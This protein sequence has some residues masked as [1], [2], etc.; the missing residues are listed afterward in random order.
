MLSFAF[1]VPVLLYLAVI[2]GLTR[3]SVRAAG[4]MSAG[5]KESASSS[6]SYFLA[7]RGIGGWLA[8]VSVVATETSVAT[9][10]VF[11]QLGFKSGFAL[12]W[13][14]P[15]Y[16]VGR[17]LVARYYL[18][19]L[20]SG[21]SLS[22]YATVT[23]TPGAQRV[24]SLA[25]LA[26][27]YI[28][29]GVRFYLGGFAFAELLGWPLIPTILMIG[30]LAGAYSLAG[31]LRAVVW[32]D[33]LQGYVILAMGLALGVGLTWQIDWNLVDL[34]AASGAPLLSFIDLQFSSGNA[35][36]AGGLFLGG[37]VLS[38]GTHGADQD[39][40]QRVLAT[41]TLKSAQRALVLSG[42]GATVV[43]TIYLALGALLAAGAAS[44]QLA[45]AGIE[46]SAKAPLVDYIR[47]IGAAAPY[48]AGS[49]AVLL[50]AAAMST[51]DSAL[52]STGAVW[53]S[54]LARDSGSGAGE[55]PWRYSL[56][57][58]VI[59]TLAAVLF[60]G[61]QGFKDFL[62][63]AM[64]SMNY[65]NG[66]LIGVFSYYLWSRRAAPAQSGLGALPI[67]AALLAGFAFTCAANFAPGLLGL[68]AKLAWTY[69]IIVSSA[70]AFAA[71]V[72]AGR[73]E[74]R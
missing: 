60:A 20:Y 17:W 19:P 43:I 21:H 39:M 30:A 42:V 71:A 24:L 29:S 48:V 35:L 22:M 27:K 3:Y 16:I 13:L 26:A 66:G 40:L 25:Y 44:G 11:P 72:M 28:S 56:R 63:L 10:L 45:A 31:G 8:F 5:G 52:H 46:I 34:S 50:I 58:L 74:G 32:T 6:A 68:E 15:G 38:I 53:Q 9:V 59:L 55:K 4:A 2:A 14:C 70:C 67:I 62:S 18:P 23:R 12:F 37:V 51:L 49:F 69:T 73:R 57:S 36:F 54:V 1:F 41:R 64:S 61:A 65:V 7:G 47:G 33:Q